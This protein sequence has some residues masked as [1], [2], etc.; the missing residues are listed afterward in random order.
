MGPF[1]RTS[2]NV[3]KILTDIVWLMLIDC[4]VI[5]SL[6]C[7]VD[8]ELIDLH[9][10]ETIGRVNKSLVQGRDNVYGRADWSGPSFGPES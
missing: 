1:Q 6:S 5:S 7:S 8:V 10:S 9:Q 3:T 2:V 4:N